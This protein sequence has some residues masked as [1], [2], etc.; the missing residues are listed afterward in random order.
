ML[1]DLLFSIKSHTTLLAEKAR[2][3][4]RKV[5]KA[6]KTEQKQLKKQVLNK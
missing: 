6:N 2:H 1:L 4:R 5:L 3:I